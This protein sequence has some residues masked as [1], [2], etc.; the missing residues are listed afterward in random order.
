MSFS[1][2]ELQWRNNER[3]GSDH[4]HL[5][6]LFNHLFRQRAK[7]ISKLWVT[8]LCEGTPLVTGGFHSGFSSQRAS[9]V[10]TVSIS[11]HHHAYHC[12]V[13]IVPTASQWCHNERNSV[14]NH[15]HLHCLLN[16]WFRWRSKKTSKFSFTGLCAVNSPVTG[17]FPAQRANNMEML[18][19]DDITIPT[20]V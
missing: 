11:W 15:W 19:F 7:K 10:K 17:E 14:S 2:F 13:N 16:C 6:C 8:D 3:D 9:N 5:D 4:W 18:P 20:I 12:L 1:V